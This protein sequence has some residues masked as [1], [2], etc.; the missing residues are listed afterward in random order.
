MQVK[1]IFVGK[2][3]E[4][5]NLCNEYIKRLKAFCDAEI[6]YVKSSTRKSEA[7]EIQKRIKRNEF[8]FVLD[9]KGKQLSSVDFAK[10]IET[11][12]K[13]IVFVVGGAFGIDKEVFKNSF[14]LSLSKLTLPHAIA[15]LIIC[16]SV[17]RSFSIINNLPYHKE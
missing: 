9:E 15:R 2:K 11:I 10:L 5:D 16:E 7:L 1:F 6:I 12:G 17:Y 8:I 14:F 13:S 4:L 3:F